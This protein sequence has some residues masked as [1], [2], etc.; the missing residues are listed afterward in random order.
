M[1]VKIFNL[2]K[3]H[4]ISEKSII[5]EFYL[6]LPLSNLR[7]LVSKL[8]M[9]CLRCRLPMW[10]D[11]LI[12][13]R[14]YRLLNEASRTSCLFTPEL[15]GKPCSR[16]WLLQPSKEPSRGF[17]SENRA[18]IMR[19]QASAS[20]DDSTTCLKPAFTFPPLGRPRF[21][22][23]VHFECRTVERSLV[24]MWNIILMALSCL[25][26]YTIYVKLL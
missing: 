7:C 20:E 2:R 19:Y 10:N 13:L 22:P 11:T 15:L 3:L 12:K 4:S 1:F 5:I 6:S 23:L 18:I 8:R 17:V 16:L 9:P 25:K 21:C 26:Y 14:M 24:N